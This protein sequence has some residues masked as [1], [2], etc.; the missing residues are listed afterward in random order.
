MNYES[1]IIFR[2]NLLLF[3]YAFILVQKYN[4]IKFIGNRPCL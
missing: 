3:Q 2:F 4:Q 1:I